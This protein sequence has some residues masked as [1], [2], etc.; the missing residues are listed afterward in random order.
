MRRSIIM[1]SF[2]LICILPL[3]GSAGD[4]D[5]KWPDGITFKGTSTLTGYFSNRPGFG[6]DIPPH[7][8]LWAYRGQL[9]L[10]GIPV[11]SSALLSTM[12]REGYQHMN[13]FSLQI[14]TRTLL[15]RGLKTSGLRFL[16]HVES[17]E[18][19]RIRP[20]YSKLILH[21]AFL[22]GGHLGLR[23]GRISAAA[24]YGTT[25]QPVSGNYLWSKPYK[26]EMFYGRIGYGQQK[27]KGVYLSALRYRDIPESHCGEDRFYIQRPDTFI[28]IAD[29]F[30]IPAD[31]LSLQQ[32]PGEGLVVGLEAGCFLLRGR[33]KLSGEITGCINTTNTDSEEIGIEYLPSC[34]SSLYRPRL[35]TSL[36]YAARIHGDLNLS[37][38]KL[39]FTAMHIAPGYRTAGVPFMRQDYEGLELRATRLFLKNRL[40]IQPWAHTFQDNHSGANATTTTTS[41]G[42]ITAFWRPSELPWFS[43]TWSPHKQHIAGKQNHQMSTAQIFSIATGKSYM[44]AKEYNATTGLS[45]SGQQME[46]RSSDIIA[47]HTGNQFMLQQTLVLKVPLTLRIEAGIYSLTSDTTIHVS[48][49]WSL[50]ANYHHGKVWRAGLSIRYQGQSAQHRTGVAIHFSADLGKAGRLVFMAEPQRYRDL[51]KPKKEYNQYVVRCSLITSF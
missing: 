23:F 50:G 4:K 13:Y 28:H 42:G 51:F 10:F 25:L 32:Y 33:V 45:W 9:T 16:R 48:G 14:D 41:I 12:Q 18:I 7:Y 17:F 1:Y 19:G 36:S 24:V 3:K 6:Q 30:F 27:D 29:T 5:K 43:L 39:Q 15:Q 46:T 37:K 8:L 40:M 21:G 22:R 35:S 31:T 2:L 47:Q 26:Q 11:N 38:T 44:I 20:L 49:L 34:V